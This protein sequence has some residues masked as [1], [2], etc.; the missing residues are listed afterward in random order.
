[1]FLIDFL[2]GF[3]GRAMLDRLGVL[4]TFPTDHTSAAVGFIFFLGNR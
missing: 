3:R 2:L 4:T 1:M